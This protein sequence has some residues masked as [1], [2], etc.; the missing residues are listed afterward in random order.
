MAFTPAK[1]ALWEQET[2]GRQVKGDPWGLSLPWRSNLALPGQYRADWLGCST[3]PIL[4]FSSIHLHR[5][6]EGGGESTLHSHCK[7]MSCLTLP[8]AKSTVRQ[9]DAGTACDKAVCR[10][11]SRAAWPPS[12]ARQRRLSPGSASEEEDGGLRRLGVD[13]RRAVLRP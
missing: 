11:W 8:P 6:G 3:N 13:R 5:A 10:P 2:D 12:R 4:P 7:A 1:D 9:E